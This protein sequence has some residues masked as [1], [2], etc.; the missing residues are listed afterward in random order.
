MRGCD[1]DGFTLI[2]AFGYKLDM[3][4]RKAKITYYCKRCK[5]QNPPQALVGGLCWAC[6]DEYPIFKFEGDE[7]C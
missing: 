1:L 4:E 7:E 6:D 2:R 3:G 5:M